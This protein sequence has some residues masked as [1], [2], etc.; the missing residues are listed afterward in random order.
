[1][2]QIVFIKIMNPSENLRRRSDLSPYLFHF[3]KDNGVRSAKEIIASIVEEMK[4][5]SN[6]GYICFTEQPLI[7]CDEMFQYFGRFP[8]PM[9]QPYGI[10][11]KRD[12]LYR[13]GAR[14]VIYGT[15]DEKF[16]IDSSL[17]WRFLEM[18]V[19]RY[20]FS[21]LREWRLPG[22]ELDFSSFRNEDIIVVTPSKDDEDVVFTPDYEVDFDYDSDTKTAMP[23]TY[24]TGASRAWRSINFDRVRK[25]KMSDYMV[26]ASTFF[27]QRIGEDYEHWIGED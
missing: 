25:K 5:K 27:E 10:G 14:N 24:I 9:Y 20:D 11:F 2:T 26:D 23:Y 12:V 17:H 7:M 16:K 21:W 1:M 6:T 4:L 3:T 22:D 15:P 19:D 18:D 8:K 13:L